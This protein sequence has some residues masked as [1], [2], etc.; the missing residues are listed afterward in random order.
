MIKKFLC[1][2]FGHKNPLGK[3]KAFIH[4]ISDKTNNWHYAMKIMPCTRCFGY[5][6]FER[7]SEINMIND[8]NDQ[9]DLVD[10]PSKSDIIH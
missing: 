2:L 6:K 4:L 1:F 9:I 5:F 7:L 10:L 8:L 3:N